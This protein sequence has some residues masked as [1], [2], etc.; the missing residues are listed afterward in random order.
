MAQPRPSTNGHVIRETRLWKS[1]DMFNYALT[2]T[3]NLESGLKSKCH[4]GLLYFFQLHLNI[5]LEL[6]M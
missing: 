2:Q 3:F 1:A 6:A 5:L 4:P